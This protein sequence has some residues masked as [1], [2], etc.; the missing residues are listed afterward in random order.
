[1]NCQEA[2]ELIELFVLGGLNDAQHS[3]VQGHLRSCSDCRRAESEY[4]SVIAVIE[5]S[6]PSELTSFDFSRKLKLAVDAQ[7]RKASIRIRFRR[8]AAPAGSIAACLVLAMTTWYFVV[9]PGARP[10]FLTAGQFAASSSNIRASW[11]ASRTKSTVCQYGGTECVGEDLVISGKNMYLVDKASGGRILAVDIETGRKKWRS[12]VEHCR[13]VTTDGHRV[14]CIA[15]RGYGKLELVGL[16]AAT[17][18]VRWRYRQESL[19]HL[20][21]PSGVTVLGE[22][23]VCWVLDATIH[24]LEGTNGRILW[25]GSIPQNSLLS[26]A[27]VAGRSLYVAGTDG[28]Y[29]L[30][31]ESGSESWRLPYSIEMDRKTRPLL[32]FLDGYLYTY[33]G[34]PGSHGILLCTEASNRKVKWAKAISEVSHICVAKEKVY[35]RSGDVQALDSRTGELAWKYTSEGAGPLI[36]SSGR[37]YFVDSNNRGRLIALNEHTGHKVWELAGISSCNAFAKLGRIGYLRTDAGMIH[38]VIIKG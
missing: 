30:D 29:C 11:D 20:E 32:A 18:R 38:K 34:I 33:C 2:T 36:C 19:N 35:V 22:G 17:G 14:Y 21:H 9:N 31:V 4:R 15:E 1:M 28:I 23:R 10:P 25:T 13:Y 16:D 12:E 7:I 37:I 3:A 8:V 6:A 24:M 5:H 26:S 27:S